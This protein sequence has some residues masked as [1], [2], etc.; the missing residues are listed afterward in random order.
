MLK[1]DVRSKPVFRFSMSGEKKARV[2]FNRLN[3][4]SQTTTLPGRC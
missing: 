2:H 4:E 3:I 1:H